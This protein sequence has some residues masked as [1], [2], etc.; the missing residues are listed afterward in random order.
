MSTENELRA[1]VINV[2]DQSI[3]IG[4]DLHDYTNRA[5]QVVDPALIALSIIML[6]ERA[7]R[8]MRAIRA[9]IDT[10]LDDQV[11]VLARSVV[12]GA[13]EMDYLTTNTTRRTRGAAISLPVEVKAQLFLTHYEIARARFLGEPP[14][15]L[16]PALV[17]ARRLRSDLHLPTSSAHWHCSTT[18]TI[19]EELKARPDMV[20]AP[21]A[22][23]RQYSAFAHLSTYA[24]A[25]PHDTVYFGDPSKHGGH[26]WL[27]MGFHDLGNAALAAASGLHALTLWGVRVDRKIGLGA[28]QLVQELTNVL[29]DLKQHRRSG[30]TG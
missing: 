18:R 23:D 24:H 22:V 8:A 20:G 2:L 1:R 21:L 16:P 7:W 17:E 14:L 30:F 29:L 15:P 19:C 13:L 6:G 4:H 28:G 9:M 26:L 25:H 3:A 11:G 5:L 27:R 10:N 12:E